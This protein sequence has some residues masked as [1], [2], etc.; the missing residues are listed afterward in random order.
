MNAQEAL[1][2]ELIDEFVLAAHTD[3][4]RVK[5][6]VEAHPALLTACDAQGETAL[7][8][9]AHMGNREI[10]QFLVERGVPLDLHTAVM[11]GLRDRVAL[12]LRDEQGLANARGEHDTTLIYYAAMNGDPTLA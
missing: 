1:S 2:G 6:L 4:A 12:F 11:L 9:S 3:L 5:E 7:S 8:A 10:A